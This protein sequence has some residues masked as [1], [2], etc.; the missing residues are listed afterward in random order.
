M[1]VSHF[2]ARVKP[3]PAVPFTYHLTFLQ[4]SQVA[5]GAWQRR[6]ATTRLAVLIYDT[7]HPPSTPTN[8]TTSNTATLQRLETSQEPTNINAVTSKLRSRTL[9][10]IQHGSFEPRSALVSMLTSPTARTKRLP[11]TQDRALRQRPRDQKVAQALT[12]L[13]TPTQTPKPRRK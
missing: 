12:S 4:G 1:A 5:C 13:R 6:S 7:H 2:E 10:S 11:T 8:N 9:S 3:A